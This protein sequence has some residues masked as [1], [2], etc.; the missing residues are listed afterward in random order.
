MR[1]F[2]V[3]SVP[4]PRDPRKSLKTRSSGSNYYFFVDTI[5][6][7]LQCYIRW[8]TFDPRVAYKYEHTPK[9]V[10]SRSIDRLGCYV[11][12]NTN[13]LTTN[14]S[15]WNR[16][17]RSKP[18]HRNQDSSH[19]NLRQYLICYNCVTVRIMLCHC[20]RIWESSWLT[21]VLRLSWNMV[22]CVESNG[23][24]HLYW[25]WVRRRLWSK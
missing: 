20:V 5:L 25:N 19:D 17:W 3:P 18:E 16:P 1:F 24:W 4:R 8:G 12:Q 10:H 7:G 22:R 15:Q 11:Y 21:G 14:I 9:L 13:L 2:G 23:K 6:T